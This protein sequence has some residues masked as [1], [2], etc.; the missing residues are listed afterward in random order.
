MFLTPGFYP[1][2]NDVPLRLINGAPFNFA[3]PGPGR[4][5]S[6]LVDTIELFG[7]RYA[8]NSFILY[9]QDVSNN[10]TICEQTWLSQCN[11]AITTPRQFPDILLYHEEKRL[12]F[13]LELITMHGPISQRRRDELADLCRGAGIQQAYI[14]VFFS[15]TDF[16][17]HAATIAWDSCVWMAQLPDHLIYYQ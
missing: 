6:L 13:F 1:H 14:S 4:Q 8:P 2:D 11:I 3:S 17:P 16:Q 15:F 5:N 9:L 12:L 7:P 10:I